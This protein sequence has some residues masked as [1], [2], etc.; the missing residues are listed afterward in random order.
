MTPLCDLAFKYKSDKCPKLGLSYTPFY[1]EL[2]KDKKGKVKKVFEFGVGYPESMFKT[3]GYITGASLYM[4][5]EFFPNA[6][7]Y[8]ADISEKAQVKDKR[9]KTFI[10]D[11]MDGKRVK[12]ILKMAGYDIDL[13]VDD[14]AHDV[15]SQTYLFKIVFPLLKKGA[16]YVIE[17]VRSTRHLITSLKELGF[18]SFAP[19][20]NRTGCRDYRNFL[21]YAIK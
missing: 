14:A 19:V 20:L 16:V 13:F 6:K 1:Y 3:K 8:G 11:Q 17:D 2:F 12:N 7:I 18:K 21:V 5:R 4:W 9:I 10:C 15:I